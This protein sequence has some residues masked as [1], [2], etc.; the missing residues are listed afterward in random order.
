MSFSVGL[1]FPC[2]Q[3][4]MHWDQW[5][6]S[7]FHTSC[8]LV[9]V[10]CMYS[11]AGGAFLQNLVKQFWHTLFSQA[12]YTERKRK[13]TK[14]DGPCEKDWKTTY[15]YIFFFCKTLSTDLSRYFYWQCTESSDFFIRTTFYR[16]S[17]YTD[18]C[19]TA[20]WCTHTFAGGCYV[21]GFLCLLSCRYAT[22]S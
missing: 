22:L 2:M 5:H 3:C 18:T 17:E 15:I 6:S 4:V 20:V 12:F 16:T 10:A 1:S 13:T 7:L 8:V 9:N 21:K 19:Y 14:T 11:Q